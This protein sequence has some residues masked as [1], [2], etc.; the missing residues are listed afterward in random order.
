MSHCLGSVGIL[1]HGVTF[2]LGSAKVCLPA[3]RD[4]SLLLCGLLHYATAAY[5]EIFH[6]NTLRGK[7]PNL[8]GIFIGR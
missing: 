8:L 3:I 4:M 1:N 5:R 2:N 6:V 7:L